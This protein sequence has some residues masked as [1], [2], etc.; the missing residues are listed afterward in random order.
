MEKKCKNICTIF[1]YCLYCQFIWHNIGGS[2]FYRV[3]EIEKNTC[4]SGVNRRIKMK[5]TRVLSFAM[6]VLSIAMVSCSGGEKKALKEDLVKF[7]QGMAEANDYKKEAWAAYYAASRDNLANVLEGTVIPKYKQ[8][9]AKLESATSALTSEQA[10]EIGKQT[11]EVGNKQ[12][13][14]F[15]E[16]LEGLK[17]QA[18]AEKL[19][20]ENQEKIGALFKENGLEFRY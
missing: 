17:L 18:E 19:A 11:V 10:K 2:V 12:L 7:Q 1:R 13:T 3:C 6:V 9:N 16:L 15:N 20:N 4:K 5:K 14:A 8:Y